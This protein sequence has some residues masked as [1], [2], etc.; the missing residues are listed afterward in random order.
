MALNLKTETIFT[1]DSPAAQPPLP[2]DQI[3]PHFPQLE[4]LECLGRGGMGVVYK[5]RQ[6]TLNRFVALKLLAPERVHDAKFAERF[7]REAQALAALN[8]PNIVTIHD[9]GQAGGFYFLLMEFVDGVNLRQLLR[10]RKFTPEEALAIV[11]PLCD[12]LQFAHERGIVHRDIKPENLLLDKTGRVKVADF[13]IAKMLGNGARDPS[14]DATAL[15]N[16]TKTALGTPGYSAPEQKSDPQRVDSRADIY[17]L[18]VVFYEMLTGELPGKSIE[19]PSRK[20]QIDVRLDQVV[21]R[22]LAKTPELRFQQA[23]EVKTCVEAIA[24][25]SAQPSSPPK[26]ALNQ[27]FMANFINFESR[28]AAFCFALSGFGGLAALSLIPGL[29][30]FEGAYGFLGFLGL[31][32]AIEMVHRK[33]HQNLPPSSFGEREREGGLPKPRSAP[34]PGRSNVKSPANVGLNPS[35]TAM[36]PADALEQP[37][38]EE[39]QTE[40]APSQFSGSAL[41]GAWLIVPFLLSIFFWDFGRKGGTAALV[42]VTIASLGFIA[43]LAATV[44]G[45]TALGQIR[46]S[47]GRLRGRQL[48]MLEGL[49]LPVLLVDTAIIFLMLLANKLLNV[50]V[51]S[52]WFPVLRDSAFLNTPHYILWLLITAAAVIGIDYAIINRVWRRATLPSLTGPATPPKPDHF[53]RW[54][55]VSLVILAGIPVLLVALATIDPALR[56][57]RQHPGETQLDLR[58]A[59][60]FGPVTVGTLTNE[61]TLNFASGRVVSQLPDSVKQNG[62]VASV[63]AA[64]DWMKQQRRDA[65]WIEYE[66]LLTEGMEFQQLKYND[67]DN[68]NPA[69]LYHRLAYLNPNPDS[70]E[71][72]HP[73]ATGTETL[74]FK[75]RSGSTGVLQ[76]SS[77]PGDQSAVQLRFKLLSGSDSNSVGTATKTPGDQTASFS[78]VNGQVVITNQTGGG[79]LHVTKARRIVQSVGDGRWLIMDGTNVVITSIK[80]AEL[81]QS[82]PAEWLGSALAWTN[83]NNHQNIGSFYAVAATPRETVAVGIDGRIATR[84]AATC[85]WHVQIFAGDPDFRGI[86]YAHGQYIVVR[87]QGSIMTS[88]DGLAWTTRTS[89]VTNNLLGVFW[90]GHQYLAGGDKGTLLASPDGVTWTPRNTGSEIDLSG[91]SFSGTRYV[92]VGNDGILIS[93]DALTWRQP[94]TWATTARVPFISS[95]WTGSEFLACGLGLD[96]L[97]T[98]YTSPDG[99]TWTL[100]DSTI[101]ASLRAAISVGGAIYVAGDSVVAKSTDGGTTWTNIFPQTPDNRLFMGLASDGQ[102]LIAVGFNHNVWSWPFVPTIAIAETW[103]PSLAPGEKPDLTAIRNDIK[104]QMDATNNDGALQRQLWYFN[105]AL[106]NGESDAVRLSFGVM[107]WA[108][109]GQ[110]DPAARQALVDLRDQDLQQ[111]S[112]A[113]DLAPPFDA[114]V[115]PGLTPGSKRSLFDLYQEISSLNRTLNDNDGY[116]AMVKLMVDKNPA[117]ARH[118]GY[119]TADDAFDKLVKQST[120]PAV[121][122][123]PVEGQAAF[124]AIRKQWEY[125]SKAEAHVADIRAQTQKKMDDFYAQHG[126]RPLGHPPMLESSRAA[127]NIFVDKTRHLIEILLA[128]GHSADATNILAQALALHNDPWLASALMDA[129]EKLQARVVVPGNP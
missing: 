6:K 102:N 66:G 81:S 112:A 121:Q 72:L 46:R 120:N 126:G 73:P 45:W 47:H 22:A 111:F 3:A 23:S 58:P 125:L 96:K 26:P 33:W 17:S 101:T 55:A 32:V 78:F 124:D 63:L 29:E 108:E 88:P 129:K 117:M 97:P 40:S 18:G 5:A 80:P 116:S 24:G 39:A 127:D 85:V 41:L 70:H 2:P 25:T 94:A 98:I 93:D 113:L 7:A 16:A 89:P 122:I 67:W 30:R 13:G 83:W 107:K 60:T 12:A 123:N 35:P 74:G 9:F 119:K 49:L 38:D 37:A 100:R 20:V 57:A 21:L 10:A 71:F 8:H 90:D 50:C 99:E 104:T 48:A 56:N 106:D 75:T 76:I 86:L 103:S 91:F 87:E 28:P 1:D 54:F 31:A 14:A 34:V 69:D 79:H 15:D 114:H 51:L 128:N 105:H 43:I 42:G 52:A 115:L 62:I 11:P 19:P 36:I 61:M 65:L 64:V 84:D 92:V 53:W 109:L 27:R 59:P 82:E 4:I 44:L 118:L 95:T 110:K 68:G 77:L